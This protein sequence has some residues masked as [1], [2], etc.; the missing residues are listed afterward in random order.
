[1]SVTK[2]V[3]KPSRP[4]GRVFGVLLGAAALVATLAIVP[5]VDA[6]GIKGPDS[7]ADLAEALQDSVVN[8]STSQTVT[9]ERSIPMPRV[10]EGSPFQEFFEEFFRGQRQGQ[11]QGQQQPRKSQSLGSGFV[12]DASGIIVTNNHVIEGADEIVA[13]F[14][15]GTKLTAELIGTDKKTD[16]AVLRVKP[17]ANKPLKAVPWGDSDKARVGDWVMAIGNPFGLGGSVTVGIVSARNRDINS[18]PYDNFIQ[19]DAAINRGNSGGPLF[20]MAGE[21]V[22]IN[23]AI[24][25]PSGGSIGIGFAIPANT[26]V[27]VVNQITEFGETRRGWLGV[28]IQGVTEEIAESLGLKE[29]KGALI[30]GVTEKGPA[31]AAG[32]VAGDVILKFDGKDVPGVRELPRMVADTQVGKPVDVVILRKGKE[33]TLKVTLGRLEEGEKLTETGRGN[34]PTVAPVTTKALGLTLGEL[35]PAAREKFKIKETVTGVVI[36]DVDAGSVAAEKRVVA[37]D[38]IVEV[39]QEAVKTPADVVS[40]IEALKKDGRRSALLLLSNAAGE[41]RFV[42][43]RIE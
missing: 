33:E 40:R 29:P 24:I 7:V 28:R 42:A 30:A 21:V 26:A 41:L 13:N 11:G 14:A 9:A 12:I 8:I 36:G 38:V 43:I 39:A 19:T 17:D 6:R 20:N 31:E 35:N 1:M 37:G 5:G 18:G 3:S 4:A 34:A 32:I 22:G 16:I 10:P 23:T 15:D 2:S 27:A 25:S